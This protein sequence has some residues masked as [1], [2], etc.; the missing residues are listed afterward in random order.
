LQND[1][2]VDAMSQVVSL[3]NTFGGSYSSTDVIFN[4]GGDDEEKSE[5]EQKKERTNKKPKG[6]TD[7]T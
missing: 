6:K 5:E 4:T 1:Q 2:F 7:K 3:A